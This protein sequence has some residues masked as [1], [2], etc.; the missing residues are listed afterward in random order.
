MVGTPV[1]QAEA[2]AAVEAIA[3]SATVQVPAQS[4]SPKLTCAAA[5]GEP[6]GE[7]VCSIVQAARL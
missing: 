6:G 1:H 3:T 4:V 7:I 2:L 5:G